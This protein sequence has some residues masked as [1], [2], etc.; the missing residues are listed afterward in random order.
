MYRSVSLHRPW[1]KVTED[2]Y[3]WIFYLEDLMFQGH[4]KLH[5]IKIRQVEVFLKELLKTNVTS[6]F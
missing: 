2:S 4:Y 6:L 1:Q 3:L 5:L